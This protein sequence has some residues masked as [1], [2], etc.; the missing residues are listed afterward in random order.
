VLYNL[1]IVIAWLVQKKRRN[2]DE[3]GEEPAK[4]EAADAQ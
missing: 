2:T 4:P 1:S 3:A